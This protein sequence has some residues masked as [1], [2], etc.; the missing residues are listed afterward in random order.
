MKFDPLIG[1]RPSVAPYKVG[2]RDLIT[3]SSPNP[4]QPDRDLLEAE[5]DEEEQEEAGKAERRERESP[6]RLGVLSLLFSSHPEQLK[7]LPNDFYLLL[8]FVFTMNV[9]CFLKKSSLPTLMRLTTLLPGRGWSATAHWRVDKPAKTWTHEMRFKSSI[10]LLCSATAE[11][12]SQWIIESNI[13]L[14]HSF[15]K[16]NTKPS[17]FIVRFT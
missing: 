7:V 4:C 3:M 10:L 8:Q 1:G 17:F 5:Q 12:C 15:T 2:Q 16:S 13:Q 6:A 14:N 11:L 9:L